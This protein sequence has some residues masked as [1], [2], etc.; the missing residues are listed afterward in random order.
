[1][2]KNNAKADKKDAGM[3]ALISAVGMLLLGAPALGYFY[4]GKMRKGIV[5]LIG[6]WIFI[7]AVIAVYVLGAVASAGVGA[8]CM[9]PVFLAIPVFDLLIVYDT[10]LIAKGEKPKLPEI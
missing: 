5:Y 2:A 6:N 10:Y 1:M 8:L 7:G 4:L 9:L 3:T